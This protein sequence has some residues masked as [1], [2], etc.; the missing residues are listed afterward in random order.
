MKLFK[1]FIL[2]WNSV[3]PKPNHSLNCRFM[4]KLIDIIKELLR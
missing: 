3:S 1:N 2:G 4:E